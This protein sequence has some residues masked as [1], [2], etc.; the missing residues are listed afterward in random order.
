MAENTGSYFV[1]PEE[2]GNVR[3][4]EEVVMT[5]AANAVIE[6][7]GVAGLATPLQEG[8]AGILGRKFVS[9]GVKITNEEEGVVLDILLRVKYG[10]VIP[11]L[12]KE[13][14]KK[15]SESVESMTGLAVRAVN[16]QVSG[17]SFE[18]EKQVS[19]KAAEEPAASPVSDF[20]GMKGDGE[21]LTNL[22]D[23]E[24][25]SES[26]TCEISDDEIDILSEKMGD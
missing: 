13:V 9:G 24:I 22:V 14:Q 15:V 16:I 23:D 6:V 4:S 11:D 7:K 21:D 18:Q 17:V 20:F 2:I 1:Q 10:F 25:P 12:C 26:E 3:I 19:D 5:I 8:L